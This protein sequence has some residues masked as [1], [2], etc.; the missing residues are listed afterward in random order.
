MTVEDAFVP[1]G[2]TELSYTTGGRTVTERFDPVD[3]YRL[4]VEAFIDAV[5]RG[6]PP[7]TDGHDAARTMAV[8]DALY[9]SVERDEP[10]PVESTASR[11]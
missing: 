11:N 6:D 2:E 3:Q 8:I 5:E 10:V 9:E 7:R 1:G 4:E